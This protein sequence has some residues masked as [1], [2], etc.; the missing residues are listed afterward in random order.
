MALGHGSR[1]G[2]NDSDSLPLPRRSRSSRPSRPRP[3]SKT[4]IPNT[5][6]ED[7][8]DNRKVITFCESYRHALEEKN[9]GQ[10]LKIA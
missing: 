1:P 2:S 4:Y 3:C 8:G 5:D 9:V 7:S 6:V 10:L